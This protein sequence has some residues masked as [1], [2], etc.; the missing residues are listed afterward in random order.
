M[1]NPTPD[2]TIESDD[3][4]PAEHAHPDP[5]ADRAQSGTEDDSSADQ[6][7]IES[8]DG[9]T[10]ADAGV[11]L[12]SAA[13]RRYLAWGAL[14]VCSVVALFALVQ[15]YGSVANAIDLW[16]EPRHQPL[17]RAAFNLVVLLASLTGVSLVVRELS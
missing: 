8:D 5:G 9:A 14:G 17:M 2:S 10:E 12:Q 13:V 11:D 4:S 6:A 3:E 7:P 15:F 1:S 16:I